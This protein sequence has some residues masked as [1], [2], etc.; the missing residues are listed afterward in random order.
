MNSKLSHWC[1]GFLEAGWLTAIVAVPLF[2]NIHS[3]RVFEP[4]KLT[5]LRSIV[6]L[7]SVAWLVK[8][9]NEQE[10]HNLDLAALARRRIGVETAVCLACLSLSH[11]LLAFLAVFR[12]PPGKLGGLLPAPARHL[13]DS[14]LHRCLCP[15]GGNHAHASASTKSGNG[16]YHRQHS[17]FPSTVCCS[18]LI[19]IPCPGVVTPNAELPGTWATP[20]S[21]PPI[22]SWPCP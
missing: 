13:H 21:L 2:F 8:F 18:V 3:D 22:S 16:R 10:W 7:M 19:R 4:D 5:L 11:R 9:I 14:F 1:N 15:H 20:S 12:H 17:Q 6:L